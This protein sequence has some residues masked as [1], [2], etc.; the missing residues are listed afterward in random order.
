MSSSQVNLQSCLIPLEEII[1]ATEDF[2]PERL[3]GSGGFGMVYKGQLSELWQNRI[4]AIKRLDLAG[5]QGEAEFINELQ[6]V[7]RLHHENII[8]FVGY[9][10]DGNEMIIVHDYASNGSLDYHLQDPNKRRGIKWTQRLKIC[11]GAAR[12]LDYLHSGLEEPNRVIHRDVKSANILLD[13]NF[14]A[15]I[16]DF[17]LSKVGPRNLP[18][19]QLYTKVAGTQFYLDPRYR[20][21]GILTK[22][23]DVY[24]FGVVM[25]EMLSGML[26]YLPRSIG[27][28]NAESLM[29]FVRRYEQNDE[30]KLIDNDIRDKIDIGSF[31]TFK[32][33]AYRCVSFNF[34]DRP[35]MGTIVEKID[36]ALNIQENV[37]NVDALIECVRED[38]GFRHGKPV[39]AFTIYKCLIH[40]KYL[41]AERT[42][43][44]D[45]LLHIFNS[46]IEDEYNT[47][48]M[49]YWLSNTSTL[50][51]LI[52][53]SLKFDSA[54]PPTSQLQRAMGFPSSV[55]DLNEIVQQVEAKQLTLHF[56]RQLTEC[57]QKMYG[58]IRDKLKH[59]VGLLLDL[60]IQA[61]FIQASFVQPTSVP[62]SLQESVKFKFPQRLFIL[63]GFERNHWHG[64]VGHLTTF[65]NTLKE[66]YVPP[67]IV[68]KIFAQ[69]YSYINVQLFNSLLL[70]RDCCTSNN[71][72]YVKAG[73]VE[74]EL[75]CLQA[76]EKYAGSAWDK[77]KH[78]RRASDFLAV[79][80]YEN[81]GVLIC[82]FPTLSKEQLNR[83]LTHIKDMRTETRPN[84]EI[85]SL[86]SHI[87]HPHLVSGEAK[88]SYIEDISVLLEDNS[89]YTTFFCTGL[90]DF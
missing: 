68:K 62:S 4:V 48:H 49:A 29:N 32:E 54:S 47:T 57:A 61:N 71:G 79:Y 15:K 8:S 64:I 1:R 39:A 69:T 56:K 17:G 55:S 86:S 40:L 35:M 80:E 34:K 19:T 25:F 67:T 44:F 76:K 85:L 81:N 73:L 74:L 24:S 63:G 33:I 37:D 31:N 72:K 12:G 51:F 23:S 77:L 46:A 10:N 60:C 45:R 14:V 27:D 20:E 87:Y 7:S 53:K 36:E 16:C 13:E 84:L 78:I 9:C 75:W 43:V 90:F 42:S 88:D 5:N 28:D 6:L 82:T 89:R 50:L 83:I 58:I 21:S 41:E 65:L 3:I 2:S 52:Q 18:N 66:N 22:E 30:N 38:I 59:E 70:Y 11:L 26:V